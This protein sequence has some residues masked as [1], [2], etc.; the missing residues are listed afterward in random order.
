M[1]KDV[2]RKSAGE[3]IAEWRERYSVNISDGA[4]V[5][6]AASIDVEMG[7][8]NATDISGEI[9]DAGRE[10]ARMCEAAVGMFERNDAGNIED[11]A[12]AANR[13][14]VAMFGDLPGPIATSPISDQAR[15]EKVAA[16]ANLS[17]SFKLA[18]VVG[19]LSDLLDSVRRI[20]RSAEV[21]R[22]REPG[23]G[24]PRKVAVIDIRDP[25]GAA[26][27]AVE[28]LGPPHLIDASGGIR[29]SL[30]KIFR[31]LAERE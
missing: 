14:R 15:E 9:L 23:P 3:I 5:G 1:S 30:A 29:A 24:D 12:K 31:K 7:L 4:A 25:Y 18:E 28:I 17:D 10:C 20:E 22:D 21:R 6:L 26:L 16:A 27:R 19:Y 11:F 2:E 8:R 13:F